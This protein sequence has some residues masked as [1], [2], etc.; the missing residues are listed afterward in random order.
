MTY[1]G[2]ISGKVFKDNNEDCG[3][4]D[5]TDIPLK[6]WRI[7][8]RNQEDGRAFIGTSDEEGNY[9]IT[10]DPGTYDIFY[11]LK[12][13]HWEV[14]STCSTIITDTLINENE[15]I[16]FDV[17]VKTNS[18][19]EFDYLEINA[20]TLGVDCEAEE[21]AYNIDITNYGPITSSAS[22][23]EI[24]LDEKFTFI[25]ASI[26][27][28]LDNNIVSVDIDELN[29]NE[30]ISFTLNLGTNC[31][32][33]LELEAYRLE[34]RIKDAELCDPAASYNSGS[35]QVELSCLETGKAQLTVNNTSTAS[36]QLVD[37]III[38][39]LVIGRVI[40]DNSPIE[41]PDPNG[42]PYTDTIDLSILNASTRV[43]VPQPD[44]HPGRSIP[45]DFLEGCVDDGEDY[46]T[47][48]VLNFLENDGDGFTAIDVQENKALPTGNFMEAVPRGLTDDNAISSESA[49]KYRIYFKNNSDTPSEYLTIRD[50]LPAAATILQEGASSHKF[51]YDLYENN[52]ARFTLDQGETVLAGEQGFLEFKV[53]FEQEATPCEAIE[54]SA[55]II[56]ENQE[57]IYT[58]SINTELCGSYAEF[59]DL[60][61]TPISPEQ[62]VTK[63]NIY[64]NPFID[65]SII[66]LEGE[67]IYFWSIELYDINGKMVRR[68]DSDSEQLVLQRNGLE[69]GMYIVKVLSDEQIIKTGKLMVH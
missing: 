26:P 34:A 21:V 51:N 47:G 64:P 68:V 49:I 40:P 50:T 37:Y 41:I 69:P 42:N 46:N 38:E 43:I 17:P 45:T 13:D 30:S 10:V 63:L 6:N 19:C 15:N 3:F 12:N 67:D 16:Q 52:V 25:T 36:V 65:Y 20:S 33:V 56:F 53:F 8:A 66:E 58:N 22:T 32:D 18:N 28:T 2:T 27:A 62:E 1:T 57:L 59:V 11:A 14:L 44:G 5:G 23:V 55:L 29:I 48:Y 9:A 54:N 31:E 24:V 39:D 61:D 4:D 60:V 35:F 7:E